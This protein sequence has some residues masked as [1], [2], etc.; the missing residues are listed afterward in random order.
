MSTH[1]TG[2]ETFKCHGEVKNIFEC[3]GEMV[4]TTLNNC[5][6]GYINLSGTPTF[7]CTYGFDCGSNGLSDVAKK[8]PWRVGASNCF[9]MDGDYFCNVQ[10]QEK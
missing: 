8:D 6:P 7:A 5:H 1:T 3:H 9:E 2:F 10:C 4:S